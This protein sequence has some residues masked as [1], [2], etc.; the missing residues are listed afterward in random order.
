MN[1]KKKVSGSWV[2]APYYLKGTDTET[3]TTFPATIYPLAQTATIGL[4]G[5][6]TQNGTPSPTN[7]IIPK[8]TGERTG[9]LCSVANWSNSTTDTRNNFQAEFQF[10]NGST[11]VATS[12][13]SISSVGRYSLTTT[14]Q[15]AFTRLRLKHN[16]STADI[17]IYSQSGVWSNGAT[18]TISFTVMSCNPTVS[19]GISLEQIMLNYGSTALPYEP[20]GQYKIPISSGS[21][22]TPVYLGEVQTTRKVKKL[23]LDG[24]E[25]WTYGSAYTRFMINLQNVMFL[26]IRLTPIICT[27]Y[28]TVDD[29]RSIDNVPNN[30]IY[31]G[32]SV[33]LTQL[34]IK[35]D[36][37]TT[38]ADFKS[39]LA[40]QYA[41]GTPVTVWYVLSSA[42]TGIVN[43]PLM[44]IGDYAD[45][46]SNISIPVTAG[47]DT[48]SV[49][50]TVQPSEVTANY[51]GWHPVSDVHER[52]NGA[53]T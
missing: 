29:G 12:V 19:G 27:H 48:L 24:S 37:Y 50:T 32:G 33:D 51:K 43:E 30:A 34:F 15:S 31:M 39:Y 36:G 11:L 46:V 16:G 22:T 4:K 26:G 53:W 52:N 21:T 9:N 45:E 7:P 1:F 23:V 6:T 8:G 40:T 47:G 14:T 35:T 5:N 18:F 38:A 3:I 49:D 28:I 10:L 41:A 13:K 25:N 17:N 44:K 2:D 20:Y 42:T